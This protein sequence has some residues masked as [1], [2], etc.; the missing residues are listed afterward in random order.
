M[1]S[2]S[3]KL[4][5]AFLELGKLADQKVPN[6]G[7]KGTEVNQVMMALVI[8]NLLQWRENKMIYP[9]VHEIEGDGG[10]TE[11]QAIVLAELI[12]DNIT[13]KWIDKNVRTN[14][15]PNIAWGGHH[16]V[17][18][19]AAKQ[20]LEYGIDGTNL[21]II[22]DDGFDT[23]LVEEVESGFRYPIYG[24]IIKDIPQSINKKVII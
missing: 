22:S 20:Y 5:P 11:K 1:D 3:W 15:F 9:E 24:F 4:N 12:A 13:P 2:E 10:W 16:S 18:R 21:R 6:V 7:G 23:D 19:D 8:I 17:I 14:V